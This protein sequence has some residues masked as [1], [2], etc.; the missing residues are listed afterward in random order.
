MGWGVGGE[1]EERG[2]FNNESN[3]NNVTSNWFSGEMLCYTKA[4]VSSLSFQRA[5]SYS[6]SK[7]THRKA[8]WEL[9]NEE[10]AAMSS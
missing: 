1:R 6:L 3:Q 9:R 7:H 4:P 8:D 10:S 5:E 2:T